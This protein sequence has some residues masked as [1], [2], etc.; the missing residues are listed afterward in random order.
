MKK[1]PKLL[2][3]AANILCWFRIA[4]S[5]FLVMAKGNFPLSLLFSLAFLSDSVD[6]W[7]Y[8]KFTKDRP[9]QH[10]FN[11]L[12]LTM[13][14][15]ADFC[16]VA[17]GIIHIMDNKPRGLLVVLA[18]AV[19]M[20]FWNWSAAKSSDRTYSLLMTILTYLW[21]AMMVF[22]LAAV[23]RRDCGAYWLAGLGITLLAFYAIWI[24]TRVKDRVIRRRG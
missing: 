24:P 9:Y 23:W 11:R 10:W 21:F 20:S 14:P 4:A 12:P 22:V 16:Y 5:V 15:L 7:C 18:L 17:G 13:D 1:Q 6:G 2:Y 3:E 19:G 8:R